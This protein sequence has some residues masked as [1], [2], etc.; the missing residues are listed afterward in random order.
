METLTVSLKNERITKDVIAKGE[1][2]ILEGLVQIL[3]GRVLSINGN[4]KIVVYGSETYIGSFNEMG[5][6]VNDKKYIS[7]LPEAS[8]VLLGVIDYIQN[9]ENV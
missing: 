3:D 2:V 5:A 9:P 4:I 7:F 1:N 8:T 6:S